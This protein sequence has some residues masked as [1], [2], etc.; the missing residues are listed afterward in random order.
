MITLR[1]AKHEDCRALSGIAMA[2]K[3]HWSYPEGWLRLW[4]EELTVRS[5]HI[6]QYFIRL[7][8]HTGKIVGFIALSYEET[9]AE[10]EH[11]WVL[12][13]FMAQGIGRLL[14]QSALGFCESEGVRSITVVSDPNASGF[15]QRMGCEPVG[16]QPS[17]PAGRKLPVF[18]YVP[19]AT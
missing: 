1:Q 13:Q 3:S 9:E 17:R 15:Y 11:L 6:D 18:R 8:E 10:I 7:A 16:Y 4:E 5:E 14:F 2:A 19:H 12:P